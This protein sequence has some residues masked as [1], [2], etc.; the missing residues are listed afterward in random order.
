MRT[1]IA[2]A[3]MVAGLAWS[4]AACG[5]GTG[6]GL[7]ATLPPPPASAPAPTPTPTPTP[8]PPAFQPVAATIFQ[9]PLYNPQLAVVG[10][11]WQHDH[12]RSTA[13]ASSEGALNVRDADGL[14]VAYDQATQT[15][16][17]ALPVAGSGTIMRTGEY[18]TFPFGYSSALPAFHADPS[19]KNM[20]NYCCNS[21]SISAS[22]RP[23]TVYRYV[24]FVDFFA[25]ASAG[26]TLDTVAY[27]TFAV[28]QP[29]K[30][31]EVPLS[32]IARFAGSVFGH[33]GGDAGATWI[34][35][36]SRF[37]FDF[38]KATLT[39]DMTLTMRCF[40]GCSY[41]SVV[42]T[43]SDTRFAQ[44]STTFSGSLVTAGAPS[45][46]SFSG[47]FAGPGAA[48]L[49]S[50]FQLPFFNPE[51]QKWMTAGGAIAG[52]RE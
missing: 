7:V 37:D 46:G 13:G 10:Q 35:G 8:A 9:D 25:P 40:M 6:A 47:M 44:G 51:H 14:S 17:I 26:P 38:A 3:G 31:G 12:V 39:G 28:G 48:E 19:N 41:D 43:L 15:Y 27:G 45:Q 30:A 32:G 20:T 33:F 29:T 49:M 34:D 11:G 1:N 2:T 5:G 22:D 16:Q 42:Y 24:S 52:K 23:E 36:S 4:L 21:L 50:Q 18:S